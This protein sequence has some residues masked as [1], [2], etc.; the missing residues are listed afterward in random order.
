VEQLTN[1]NERLKKR[2]NQQQAQINQLETENQVL[3]K[4][5]ADYEVEI[6]RLNNEIP[7][8]KAE[9][10]HLKQENRRLKQESKQLNQEIENLKDETQSLKQEIERLKRPSAAS[11]ERSRP[12]LGASSRTIGE[13]KAELNHSL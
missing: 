5:Y 13:F 9:I 6:Q 10:D 1:E 8:H 12:S 11:S 7:R 2:C 3:N 4:N